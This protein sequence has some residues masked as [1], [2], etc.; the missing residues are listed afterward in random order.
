MGLMTVIEDGVLRGQISGVVIQPGIDVFGLDGNDA[1]VM[2]GQCYLRRRVVCHG[3]KRKEIRLVTTIG[4]R[5]T[6]PVA[7]W[8]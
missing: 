7:D 8:A 3:C 1:P 2:T 4:K 5:S 6:Y